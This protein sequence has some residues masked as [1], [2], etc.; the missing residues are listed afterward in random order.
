[1]RIII[2]AARTKLLT[3]MTDVVLL[4]KISVLLMISMWLHRT[5]GFYLVLRSHFL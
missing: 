1:M 3:S 2:V 4:R 5:G